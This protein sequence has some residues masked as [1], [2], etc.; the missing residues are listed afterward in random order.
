MEITLDELPSFEQRKVRHRE[1]LRDNSRKGE[2]YLLRGDANTFL[3]HLDNG[4]GFLSPQ[5]ED[6]LED[7][8]KE[9]TEKLVD[10][11]EICRTLNMRGFPLDTFKADILTFGPDGRNQLDFKVY[12]TPFEVEYFD[13]RLHKKF[14]KSGYSSRK[15]DKED[16]PVMQTL[17]A[18]WIQTKSSNSLTKEIK[19]TANNE[20]ELE[21]LI[22]EL[23]SRKREISR[24]K[25]QAKQD[26]YYEEKM[27]R[28]LTAFHGAF[29]DGELV[30][31]VE[32]EGND[33]FQSFNSRASQRINTYSPQEFLDLVVAR[34]FVMKGVK[35][36][37]RGWVDIRKGIIGLTEYKRKFGDV[38]GSIEHNWGDVTVRKTEESKYLGEF[39]KNFFKNNSTN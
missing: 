7:S 20:A 18:D 4:A 8:V 5:F 23:S 22:S 34:D 35:T 29:K 11:Q 37:D 10:E 16:I 3:F 19:N 25:D 13:R 31:Y 38:Y 26:R 32:T 39:Y 27:E 6:T 28:P 24:A 1:Q 30:A 12:Q 36:F 17:I 33:S 21:K 2:F 15:L 9:I 14:R